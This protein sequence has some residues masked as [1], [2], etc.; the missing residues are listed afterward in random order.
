VQTASP[1]SIP[2]ETAV[3]V[4]G[5]KRATG[6]TLRVVVAD[7][8]IKLEVVYKIEPNVRIRTSI[9]TI[10]EKITVEKLR[11]LPLADDRFQRLASAD[12]YL[13]VI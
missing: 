5:A 7:K 12:L 11:D 13:K 1:T 8:A 10:S 6:T 2:K 3:A 4:T 9:R